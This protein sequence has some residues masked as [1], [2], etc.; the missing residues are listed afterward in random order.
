MN[1]PIIT[2][3]YNPNSSRNSGSSGSSSKTGSSSNSSSSGSYIN[4]CSSINSGYSGTSRNSSALEVLRR[5]NALRHP[6]LFIHSDEGRI[7]IPR[8]K[9]SNI[10]KYLHLCGLLE[11]L[12]SLPVTVESLL[13]VRGDSLLQGRPV[14]GDSLLPRNFHWLFTS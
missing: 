8:R 10:I 3:S 12:P 11:N 7:I 1:L 6:L 5:S 4:P 14:R 9:S 13:P 2:S